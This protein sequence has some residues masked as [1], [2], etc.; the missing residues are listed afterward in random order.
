[1]RRASVAC[2]SEGGGMTY[3]D[4]DVDIDAGA[5]LVLRIAKMAPGIGGFGVFFPWVKLHHLHIFFLRAWLGTM[6]LV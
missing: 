1:M 4:A 5:E 6:Y 3:K 2:S